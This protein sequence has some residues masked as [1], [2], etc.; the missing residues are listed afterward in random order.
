MLKNIEF[1]SPTDLMKDLLTLLKHDRQNTKVLWLILM[2]LAGI[3]IFNTQILNIF[4]RQKEIGMFMAMGMTPRQVIGVFTL[5]G[6]F[7]AI[8]ALIVVIVIG[9]P[10]FT[11]FQSVGFDVSHLSETTIP[12]RERIFLDFNPD[13]IVSCL[14]VVVTM[15]LL[16]TWWPVRKITQLDPT[17]A[18]REKAIV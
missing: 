1:Q 15:I 7:A 3:S 9:I 14:S 8:G 5:E 10:F 6:G 2:F 11:W 17:K 13:E 12:I 16:M 18:L 4:K